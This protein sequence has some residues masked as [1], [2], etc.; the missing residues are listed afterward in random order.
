LCRP[1]TS[2][3]SREINEDYKTYA[4]VKNLSKFE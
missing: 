4:N 2:T 1:P 3:S